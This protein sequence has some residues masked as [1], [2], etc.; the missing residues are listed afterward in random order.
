M[1]TEWNEA[2]MGYK[3]NGYHLESYHP[4]SPIHSSR[5]AFV[6]LHYIFQNWVTSVLN[7]IINSPP[8]LAC[9]IFGHK[10]CQ[11]ELVLASYGI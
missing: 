9:A 3:V 4:P 6:S 8:A 11:S 7:D 2:K 5:L 10:C 1:A